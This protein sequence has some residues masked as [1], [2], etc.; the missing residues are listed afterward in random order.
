MLKLPRLLCSG[1]LTFFMAIAGLCCVLEG[2]ARSQ[3]L[4]PVEIPLTNQGPFVARYAGMGGASLAFADDHAAGLRNPAT[5]GLVRSLEFA[6][7]FNHQNADMDLTYRG[8]VSST[9]YGKTRL[10]DLGFVYPFPTY[11]GSFVVGFSY[12]LLSVIDS[13]FLIEDE[14]NMEAIY[15]EGSMG[16]YAV[17]AAFQVTPELTL[18]ASGILLDGNDFRERNA[19]YEEAPGVQYSTTDADISGVTGN[20]GA[21]VDLRGGLRFGLTLFLPQKIEVEGSGIDTTDFVFKDDIDLPYRIGAGL[22]FARSSF[23]LAADAVFTDW[24]QIDYA[25][26]LRTP[27]RRNAY[28]ETV[29]LHT[30]AEYLIE[31]PTPVRLRIGYR[32]QPTPYD[33]VQPDI[34]RAPDHYARA[35]FEKDRQYFTLGAGLLLAESVVVDAAYMHGGYERLA[36]G[37]TPR[38]FNEE[39]KDRRFLASIS[40][41]L[42]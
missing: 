10:S 35:A 37:T 32:Y 18:G 23:I 38:N 16:A 11:R 25:G 34:F 24:T 13:D 42:R 21:L 14:G 30:G 41:R 39:V 6:A 33:V 19:R 7:G 2:P 9:E 12:G 20:L 1:L 3:G 27:D 28:R 31:A 8:T 17:S 29:E 26:P 4:P 40:L 36:K 22:A 15:E 5:L